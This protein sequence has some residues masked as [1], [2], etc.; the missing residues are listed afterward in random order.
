MDNKD[1]RINQILSYL[2]KAASTAA[3]GVNEVVQSAGSAVGDK[4]STFKLNMELSRLQTEQEQMFEDIG[5][6]MFM[7]K[8]GAFDQKTAEGE[9]IDGQDTVDKLLGLA[10]EKQAEI[11]DTAKKVSD[12]SGDAVCPVCSNV[13]EPKACYC[14]ACGTK[15]PEKEAVSEEKPKE[16]K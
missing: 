1:S 3:D 8:T 5:R 11:D 4:Y 14:S 2:A 13:C 9:V 6:T 15:L 10:E 7:V 16:N 12:L